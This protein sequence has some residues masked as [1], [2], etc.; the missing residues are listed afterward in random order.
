MKM[1]NVI[2]WLVARPALQVHIAG[3]AMLLLISAGAYVLVLGPLMDE[4]H[5]RMG[6]E[7]QVTGDTARGRQL[8]EEIKRTTA[9]TEAARTLVRDAHLVLKGHSALNDRLAQ[10]NEIAADCGLQTDTIEPG[11][12]TAGPRYTT[13]AIRLTTRGTAKGAM[14]FLKMLRQ[15]TP[16]SPVVG[17]ELTATPSTG[18]AEPVGVCIFEL[19]WFTS[20]NAAV[21]GEA[22][23]PGG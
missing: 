14:R 19:L 3:L 6:L 12:E 11:V 10:I 16:D 1:K 17:I 23:G 8:A 18:A 13:V 2:D 15:K 20:G 4:D 7:A 5:R 9:Q 21:A 22:V